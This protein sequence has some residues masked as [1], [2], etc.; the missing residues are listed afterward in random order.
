MSLK[1]WHSFLS[2]SLILFLTHGIEAQNIDGDGMYIL[3]TADSIVEC[4]DVS[5]IKIQTCHISQLNISFDSVAITNLGPFEIE[6]DL[7]YYRN[8]AAISPCH[9]STFIFP[10][11]TNGNYKF[12]IKS[13]VQQNSGGFF[14]Q[15][16][17]TI[18]V[19]VNRSTV[20]FNPFPDKEVLC[21]ANNFNYSLELDALAGFDHYQW[22]TGDDGRYLPVQ[23]EG[24]YSVI[25]RD[26]LGCFYSDTVEVVSDCD[27]DIYIPNSFTPNNDAINDEFRIYGNEIEFNRMMI[28]NRWGEL[29]FETMNMN[30]GWDG[31]APIG[32]YV[33]KVYYR[34]SYG[35]HKNL[36]GSVSLIR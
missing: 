14:A 19:K 33:Y 23:D 1:K 32:V 15:D 29:V 25:V 31:N 30:K 28:F 18:F 12:I 11:L 16:E 10:F 7:S 20:L 26:A 22:N 35:V 36:V 24:I 4:Q 3:V 5:E 8:G 6:I 34:D 27:S 17:D 13:S 2:I 21:E 9:D